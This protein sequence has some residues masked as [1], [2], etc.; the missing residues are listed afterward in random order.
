[1]DCKGLCSR[2]CS[3][4]VVAV[5]ALPA[6]AQT[7][8]AIDGTV[9]DANARRCPARAS[10]FGR[11]VSR[12]HGGRHEH[13]GRFRFPVIPPV[14]TR[15]RRA[16]GLQEGR[17][18]QREGQP[19][20]H[21]HRDDPDGDLGHAGD[22]RLGR[23]AHRRHHGRHDRPQHPAGGSGED[24][25][26]PQLRL[27]GRDEPSVSMDPRT[28]R[29]GPS[30]SASTAPRRS[31]TDVVDGIDRRT[32]SAASR[33]K[34]CRRSSS[35]KC[36][37]RRAAT[38]P[39]TAARWTASST[40][41]RSRAEHVKGDA[42]GY[43]EAEPDG[44]SEG[45]RDD[46][47]GLRRTSVRRR[48]LEAELARVSASTSRLRAQGPYMLL[49][50]LNRVNTDVERHAGRLGFPTPARPSRSATTPTSSP[51][52]LHPDHGLRDGRR[53]DLGDPE[54]RKGALR[55]FT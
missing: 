48:H 23:G 37:S 46:R 21:G 38:R 33:G 28:P 43:P 29:P 18:E 5:V 41:S 4:G 9:T 22:R 55:N 24:A 8:G 51:A 50:R 14:P 13:A 17:A 16:R 10:T 35:R 1:M 27:G 45:R 47:R 40:S 6:S 39:S 30:P 19:R 54:V 42:F 25:A 36:R 20:R 32:S 53:D 15:S 3:S 12:E 31:R 34:G 26:R 7:T 49:R 52:S 2:S 44:G 11:R